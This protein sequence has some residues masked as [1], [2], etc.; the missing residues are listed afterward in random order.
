MAPPLPL[1]HP[2]GTLALSLPPLDPTIF[3]LPAPAHTHT[4]DEAPKQT[5]PRSCR[6]AT[7]GHETEHDQSPF[8]NDVTSNHTLDV[9]TP[10]V[11]AV[12]EAKDKASPRKRRNGGGGGK[13]KRKEVDDGDATYPAKRTRVPRGAAAR[14]VAVPLVEEDSLSESL[15]PGTDG[16]ATPESIA[17]EEKRPERRSTR[18][19]GI[20]RRSSSASDTT[21]IAV[22][23][24][25]PAKDASKTDVDKLSHPDEGW[26]ASTGQSDKEEGELSEEGQPIVP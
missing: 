5:T 22:S 2:M 10:S 14:E 8:V 21:S 20:R 16:R 19:A 4:E 9:P 12:P 26:P 17:L 25:N 6:S 11:V 7:K 23:V 18:S 15:I 13:R 1:Y 24:T 3:G